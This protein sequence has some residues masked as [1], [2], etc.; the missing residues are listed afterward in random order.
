MSLYIVYIR[1]CTVY[2]I[3]AVVEKVGW[4]GSKMCTLGYIESIRAARA[5]GSPTNTAT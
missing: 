3:T 4:F 1:R 5:V 2:G